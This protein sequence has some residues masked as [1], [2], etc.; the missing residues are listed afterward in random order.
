MARAKVGRSPAFFEDGALDPLEGAIGLRS[1]STDEALFG[2]KL[3]DRASERLGS[4]I[5]AVV[6]GDCLQ[7]PAGSRQFV[8]DAADQGRA[9]LGVGVD[10][11]DVDVGLDIRA[12]DI[13]GGV[14]PAATSCAAQSS[15]VE[16]VELNQIA[17]PLGFQVQWLGW[18]RCFALRLGR[19]AATRARRWMRVPRPWR[20]RTL[21][22]PLAETTRPPHIGS[23]NWAATRRLAP[24]LGDRAQS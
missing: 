18:W 8:G 12:G 3:G 2:A 5:A 1:T 9:V 13:D 21:S 24:G 16:A 14:L 19:I 7:L 10:L 22:T 15:D 20:R 4:E 17:G 23:R 11:A 6:G